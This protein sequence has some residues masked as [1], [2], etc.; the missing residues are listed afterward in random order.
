[1][2]RVFLAQDPRLVHIY[3]KL[4]VLISHAL[5]FR[6]ESLDDG[7]YAVEVQ[8]E[9]GIGRIGYRVELR[10]YLTNDSI[11]KHLAN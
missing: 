2:S 4:A 7:L 10:Y 6:I 5:A 11:L 9:T 8:I 1:M 3:G